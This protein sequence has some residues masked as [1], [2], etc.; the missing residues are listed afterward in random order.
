MSSP[1]AAHGQRPVA[2]VVEDDPEIRQLVGLVLGQAGFQVSSAGSGTEGVEL[3]RSER[4]T[5]VTLDVGLPDIDGLEVSRRIRTFS[6][7][8]I[9]MLSAR[10]EELDVLLGLQ[11]GADDYLTKPFRPAELR[12]RVQSL[13]RRPRGA[14]AASDAPASGTHCALIRHRGL[15]LDAAGYATTVDGRPVELTRTE[16]DLLRCLLESGREVRT[17]IHL[18]RA[19]RGEPEDSR[20]WVS[21]MDER[22][23][24]AH[25][26]NLRRKL[27][28]DPK[29][30]RWLETVRGVGYRLAH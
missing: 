8:Y 2:V 21:T 6:D 20:S 17:R 19:L 9:L 18:V 10:G 11:S 26:G 7:A 12:A 28:D 13:Q 14:A 15:E 27:G 24:E 22:A 25:L 23:V 30:P 4:P 3:A 1:A 5:V 29:S 16:F